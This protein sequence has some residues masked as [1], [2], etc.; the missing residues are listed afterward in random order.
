[1]AVYFL[2]S[3]VSYLHLSKAAVFITF[4]LNDVKVLEDEFCIGTDVEDVE[5]VFTGDIML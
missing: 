3:T 1:M 4:G 2:I 5:R